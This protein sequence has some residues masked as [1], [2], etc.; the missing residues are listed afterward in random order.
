[1]SIMS[2]S[3]SSSIIITIIIII[4]VSRMQTAVRLVCSIRQTDLKSLIANSSVAHMG[5]V[6]GDNLF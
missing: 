3:G 1:M 4:N 5:I 2:S 6:I